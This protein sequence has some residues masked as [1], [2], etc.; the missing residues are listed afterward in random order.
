M[1]RLISGL[2][3][4]AA[5]MMF[6]GNARAQ[7]VVSDPGV[8]APA[9]AT[10]LSVAATAGDIFTMVTML[11]ASATLSSFAG[12]QDYPSSNQ[13]KD[14]LFDAKTPSSTTATKIMAD[15]ERQVTGTDA[16]GK[17]LKE[18]ITGSANLAGI[19]TDKLNELENEKP[20]SSKP[21]INIKKSMDEVA[22]QTTETKIAVKQVNKATLL[23]A[24]GVA[25]LADA[26]K[27]QAAV[28]RK[29]RADTALMFVK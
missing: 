22:Q 7:F 1:K 24:L 28:M 11:T 9:L 29:E 6:A 19:A 20:E 21:L 23:V 10:S 18:Q 13:L 8:E 2:L 3:M 17:L 5:S 27:T 16:S 25:Q 4:L 12:K 26:A 15:D 14:Q